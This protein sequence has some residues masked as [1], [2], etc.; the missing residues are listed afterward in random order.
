MKE[1]TTVK[2]E[3][4]TARKALRRFTHNPLSI[5]GLVLVLILTVSAILAP[6][7]APHDPA[8]QTLLDK[9]STPFGKYLLGADQ[10]G[11][12]ILSR[13]IYGARASLFVAFFSVLIAL[14]GGIVIGTICG[15]WG[16]L[17]DAVLMRVMI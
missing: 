13:L 11:R 15:Y 9:R 1:P 10:F 3:K 4:A 8:K 12:D 6:L 17:A 5:A 16:G 2:P 14:T 7:L